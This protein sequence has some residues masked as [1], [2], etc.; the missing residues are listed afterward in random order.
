MGEKY[1]LLS[2]LGKKC[3][4][5]LSYESGGERK[6]VHTTFACRLHRSCSSP[7]H[8]EQRTLFPCL[9]Q[10]EKRCQWKKILER[11]LVKGKRVKFKAGEGKKL[12]L[13]TR[14]QGGRQALAG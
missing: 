5:L 2:S 1:L 6:S 7:R 11:D 3:L 12:L 14:D 9:L 13:E 4:A 10:R 8:Q